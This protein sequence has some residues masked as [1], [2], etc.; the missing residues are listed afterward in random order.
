MYDYESEQV[1]K[2]LERSYESRLRQLRRKDNGPRLSL[3]KAIKAASEGR[4][5]HGAPEEWEAWHKK[6]EDPQ[7]IQLRWQDL[8]SLQ[9]L[10]T[11]GQTVAVASGGG[12]TVESETPSLIVPLIGSG[13]MQAGARV[14]DGLMGD[15][16]TPVTNA[17]PAFTWLPTE[18]SPVT[19][20][21]TMSLGQRA[22]T[23]KNGGSLI[24]VSYQLSK[25]ANVEGD[26]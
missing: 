13:V 6:D 9:D 15:Q 24:R 23:P 8:I 12:Y 21:S 26:L 7:K 5:R 22:S 11:R 3:L 16:L 10:Q 25:Q 18:G 2:E 19:E 14:R 4:F 1:R 20:D 17:L